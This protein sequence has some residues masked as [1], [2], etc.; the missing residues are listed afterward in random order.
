MVWREHRSPEQPSAHALETLRAWALA[1]GCGDLTG[2]HA[3]TQTRDHN[4][5]TSGQVDRYYYSPSG[6]PKS[7]SRT[8]RLPW[9]PTNNHEASEVPA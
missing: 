4:G 8:P 5:P 7:Y 6:K 9:K 2:W 3:T 1:R